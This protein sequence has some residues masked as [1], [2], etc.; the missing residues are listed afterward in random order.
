[1]HRATSRRTMKARRDSHQSWSIETL[2]YSPTRIVRLGSEKVAILF[3]P[4]E[5]GAAWQLYPHP[6]AF[7]GL[8]FEGLPEPL[9]PE[10]LA[11]PDLPEVERFLGIRD[12][13]P[14]ALAA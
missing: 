11:F 4:V 12:A 3:P 7:P 14:T 8:N 1:M 9:R 5:P 2:S 6:D 13:Q 10:F